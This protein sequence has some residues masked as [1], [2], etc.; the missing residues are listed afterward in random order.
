MKITVRQPVQGQWQDT[1]F[2]SIQVI[3]MTEY[4]IPVMNMLS[5]DKIKIIF[6]KKIMC[7]LLFIH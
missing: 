2:L 4:H 5:F 6:L 1:Q 7:T 3:Q